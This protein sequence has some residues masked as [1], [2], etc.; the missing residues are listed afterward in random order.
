M[1]SKNY[2]ISLIDHME[3]WVKIVNIQNKKQKQ[4]EK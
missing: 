3:V 2:Q 1:L 4:K